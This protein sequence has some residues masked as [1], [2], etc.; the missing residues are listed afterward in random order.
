MA[1]FSELKTA[2][3]KRLLD[4]NNTVVSEADVGDTI[5]ASIKYWK[6]RHFWFNEFSEVKTLTV[7]DPEIP[8]PSSVTMFRP[9]REG[10]LVLEDSDERFDITAVRPQDYDWENL[11]QSG[12]PYI[13]TYRNKKWYCY[14]YPKEAY[15]VTW[16]G[17]KDYSAL[18]SGSDENDF[19]TYAD[20]LIMFDALSRL[21]IEFRQDREMGSLFAAGAQDEYD[22]LKKTTEDLTGTGV[23]AVETI[24]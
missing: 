12:R 5:N 4:V 2:V 21:H 9:F 13:R 16:Y 20:R 6:G 10:G 11:E 3:S 22:N 1:T 23:L 15:S 19:T 24:L 14:D 18:S 17:V 8:L 7:D